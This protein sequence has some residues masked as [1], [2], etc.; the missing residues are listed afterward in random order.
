M[1]PNF[2]VD[3]STREEREKAADHYQIPVEELNTLYASRPRPAHYVEHVL[4]N[5]LVGKCASSMIIRLLHK[6]RHPTGLDRRTVPYI[7]LSRV[8]LT[9]PCGGV[10]FISF[11]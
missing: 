10:P 5:G 4:Q 11:W 1:A 2:A 3:L 8:S 9:R 6:Y 7:S